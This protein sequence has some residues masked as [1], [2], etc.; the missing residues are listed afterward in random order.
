MWE[1]HQK[2][3]RGAA[4]CHC[5]ERIMG[6]YRV[7][8][9]V[10]DEPP[11]RSTIVRNAATTRKTPLAKEEIALS[12]FLV[13]LNAVADRD[14]GDDEFAQFGRSSGHNKN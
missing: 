14:H 5:Q 8:W 7:L 9:T 4:A 12:P 2:H 10:C 13:L 11:Y 3:L 1:W 6:E